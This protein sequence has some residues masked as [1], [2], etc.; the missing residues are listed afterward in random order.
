MK[1]LFTAEERSCPRR[2]VDMMNMN[3]SSPFFGKKSGVDD[4][5]ECYIV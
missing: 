5:K 2:I 3:G 4:P 1:E